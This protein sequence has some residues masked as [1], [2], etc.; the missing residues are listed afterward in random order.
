MQNT[1]LLIKKVKIDYAFLSKQMIWEV[2][3]VKTKEYTIGYCTKKQAIKRNI[4]KEIEV[5]IEQKEQELIESNFKHSIQLE[6]DIL[7]NNMQNFVEEQKHGAKIRS[8]AKW[9]EEGERS[10]KYF[11]SVEKKK[12]FK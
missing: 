3:K 10:S 12:L 6:R 5:Q 1:K 11:Y 7:V 9:V 2:C 4:I 8:R